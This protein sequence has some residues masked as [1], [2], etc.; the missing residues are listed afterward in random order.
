MK[1]ILLF[2]LCISMLVFAGS[3]DAF[4]QKKKKKKKSKMSKTEMVSTITSL[5]QQVSDL[6]DKNSGLEGELTESKNEL[7]DANLQLEDALAKIKTLERSDAGGATLD[8]NGGM[9]F[10]IQIGAY[11]EIDLTRYF[12]NAKSVIAESENGV[13]KYLMGYFASFEEAKEFETVMRKAGFKGAW[14]VPYNNGDRISDDA[15][16][17]ILGHPIRDKK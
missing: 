5:Q 13:S 2:S 10:R 8:A 3:S 4:G 7:S 9:S 15:A 17:D 1:R 14:L 6:T 11:N 12:K 16:E